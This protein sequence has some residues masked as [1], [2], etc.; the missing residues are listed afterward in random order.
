MTSWSKETTGPAVLLAF[1]SLNWMEMNCVVVGTSVLDLSIRGSAIQP[2]PE[3]IDPQACLWSGDTDIFECQKRKSQVSQTS[4]VADIDFDVVMS[5][6]DTHRLQTTFSRS[7]R[8]AAEA[9]GLKPEAIDTGTSEYLS[10]SVTAPDESAHVLE[11]HAQEPHALEP[12]AASHGMADHRAI[13]ESI[14]SA[15]EH[16]RYN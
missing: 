11:P 6:D 7:S 16:I 15:S 14:P 10:E 5:P 9:M 1:E 3:T 4:D 12:H 8:P 13:H 2:E